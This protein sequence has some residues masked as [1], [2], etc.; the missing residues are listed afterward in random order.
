M[1]RAPEA[2]RRHG[3][4]EV[5]CRQLP[6]YERGNC[7][8]GSIIGCSYADALASR[9]NRDVQRIMDDDQYG[10]SSPGPGSRVGAPSFTLE[11]QGTEGEIV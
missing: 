6:A 7:P 4:W 9:M 10:M 11:L 5:A 8:N 2:S 3:K 1:P